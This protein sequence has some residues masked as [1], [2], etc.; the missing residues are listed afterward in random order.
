[1]SRTGR[2][3]T[4]GCML[5]WAPLALADNSLLVP[6][7]GRC[8]LDTQD[9]YLKEAI[10]LCQEAAAKGDANA[11]YELGAF[12][13]QGTRTTQS[14]AQAL[15]YFEQ[16]SLKGHAK[17]QLRL[18][19][20]YFKGQGVTANALQ[21]YIVLKMSAINGEESALDSAD[22]VEETLLKEELTLAKQVLGQIFR[23]FMHNVQAQG[24]YL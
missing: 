4:L 8:S 7:T 6:A 20:M 13:Y 5:L 21:A 1:M 10:S 18:G 14:F 16:A 22:R 17:A 24:P 23:G 12:Y 19:E 2:A 3:L 11:L 15:Y 9:A